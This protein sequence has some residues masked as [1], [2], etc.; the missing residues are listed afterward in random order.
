MQS[1]AKFSHTSV[2]VPS[3]LLNPS[4]HRGINLIFTAPDQLAVHRTISNNLGEHTYTQSGPPLRSAVDTP[5]HRANGHRPRESSTS[6]TPR[7]K[8]K[9]KKLS[10]TAT[11]TVP[12]DSWPSTRENENTH[13]YTPLSWVKERRE[14]E[15]E[16]VGGNVLTLIGQLTGRHIPHF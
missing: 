9:E 6:P 8:K 15:G 10:P 3:L 13:Y 2:L 4:L 7:K 12:A 1:R 5:R 16:G 11:H 14:E